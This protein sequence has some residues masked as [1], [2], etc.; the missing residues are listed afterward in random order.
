LFVDEENT[1]GDT[2]TLPFTSSDFFSVFARY[3]ESVWPA[4]VIL[5]VLAVISIV[6]AIRG[7]A[8]ASRG[9]NAALAV[10]WFWMGVVYHA[11]FFADIN[12]VAL[13]MAVAFVLQ[14]AIFTVLAVARTPVV[15][16]TGRK[17][18]AWI[19]GF[20]IV[21][22][23]VIYPLLSVAAGHSYPAQPTFGVPCPTTIF[24]LGIMVWG[25]GSLPRYAFVIPVL[26]TVVG[27]SA[28]LQLGVMEDLG[29]AVA[30]IGSLAVVATRGGGRYTMRSTA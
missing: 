24:T 7:T 6:L 26:W 8:A 23:T 1:A 2:M 15:F 20:L 18:S 3:N 28:V 27:T 30:M 12:P 14:G 11:G 16:A 9:V 13:I 29:L 22:G 19:G 5:Y 17:S 4:Q 25:A 10:M 21:F